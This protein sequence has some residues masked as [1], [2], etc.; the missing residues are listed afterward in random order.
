VQEGEENQEDTNIKPSYRD[1][2]ME[3]LQKRKAALVQGISMQDPAW[4][5]KDDSD[6]V[7]SLPT[8]GESFDS[9]AP[10]HR[11]STI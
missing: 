5:K 3:G 4:T 11:S 2:M 1:R 9:T 8:N 10:Q 7:P 6:T